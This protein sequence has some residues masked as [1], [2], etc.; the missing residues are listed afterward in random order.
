MKTLIPPYGGNLVAPIAGAERAASIQLQALE[1]PSIDLDWSRICQLELLLN[2][3]LSPLQGYMG[4]A[5]LE[6]VLKTLKLADGSAWPYP[7]TLAVDA[8]TARTL[9]PGQSVALRDGEGF[10][11]A[12]LHIGEIWPADPEAESA[13]A[14]GSGVQLSAPLA[15]PGQFYLAGRVEGI[16]LPPRHD[17]PGERHTPAQLRE[18]FGR[19]GWRRVLGFQPGQPM[20]RPQLE[21]VL[22]A[23]LRHEANLLIQPA[24]G[25]DPVYESGHVALV[26][27]CQATMH[28][29][30]NATTLFSLSPMMPLPAGPR[31]TLLHALV[32]RNYGCSH[33]IVGGNPQPNGNRRRG[34]DY[35]HRHLRPAGGGGQGMEDASAAKGNHLDGDGNHYLSCIDAIGVTLVPF[36]RM[37]YVEASDEYRPQ[38]EVPAFS[39][40][41]VMGGHEFNRRLRRGLNIPEWFTYPEVVEALNHAYPPRSQQGFTVFFTGLSG[42]GK[43]T[44]AKA[45]AVKLMEI[46]H[47]R[48][49]LLDGDIVRK[50]LSSELG[51]SKGHRDTNIRRIGFVAS[52]ITKH[53][54]TAICAPIAPYRDTRCAVRSMIESWGGFIEIHVATPIEVC[55]SR[56][57]KGLYAKAR[58]GLIA[59]F[60]GV[61]DP[62]EIPEAP[63]LTIDTSR[64]GVNEAVQSII[65]K[66]EHEGYLQCVQTCRVS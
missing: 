45:L 62:Y 49:T 34:Q 51:F 9:Q 44:I 42:A 29:L 5:D 28:R 60:T 24:G 53:G 7:V 46:G 47:R 3:A 59:E 10:M 18:Q 40:K 22:Q 14:D 27:A 64:H 11:P 30:P 56:D 63:E 50:H 15:R 55:E 4:R 16:A 35:F 21:F 66:L 6:N 23:A 8:E 26:R 43:S 31:E 41:Q 19:R 52:E 36:P 32:A 37:V 54:G 13:M 39:R 65:R 61:S 25:A 12:V 2:G 58:A 33:L 38:E 1:M 57:R 17:F 48:V 20:H